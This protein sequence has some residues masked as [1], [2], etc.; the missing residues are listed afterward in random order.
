MLN[1]VIQWLKKGGER[2]QAS[3]LKI[4]RRVHFGEIPE[5]DLEAALALCP[6]PCI[7][8]LIFLNFFFVRTRYCFF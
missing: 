1:I 5:R 2:C 7:N 4:L 6:D 8:R 3:A